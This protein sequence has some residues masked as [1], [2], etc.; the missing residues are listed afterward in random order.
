MKFLGIVLCFSVSLFIQTLI[1]SDKEFKDT[2]EVQYMIYICLD[3]GLNVVLGVFS[4][5][6]IKDEI[7]EI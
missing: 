6:I 1:L 3:L 5:M 7:G 4:I 2:Q